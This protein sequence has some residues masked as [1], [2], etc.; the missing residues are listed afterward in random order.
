MDGVSYN[1]FFIFF[2]IIIGIHVHVHISVH[3]HVHVCC[4]ILNS[5]VHF[6]YKYMYMN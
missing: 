2:I 4:K 5:G 3:V 1:K 6:I